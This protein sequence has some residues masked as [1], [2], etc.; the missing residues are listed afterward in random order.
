MRYHQLQSRLATLKIENEEVRIYDG[1]L[2]VQP[3]PS[4]PLPPKQKAPPRLMFPRAKEEGHIT[5]CSQCNYPPVTLALW[6]PRIYLDC[7][8]A[9]VVFSMK[10]CMK[11]SIVWYRGDFLIR[12][13][14]NRGANGGGNKRGCYSL[15]CRWLC[16]VPVS[17][18]LL[19]WRIMD[20][21]CH[22]WKWALSISVFYKRPPSVI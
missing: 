8:S 17:L 7:H 19:L 10:L 13:Q 22:Y 18:C 11:L 16:L 12:S 4:A 21:P 1:V 2:S 3:Q 15:L 6:E 20:E 5:I 14:K 9:N